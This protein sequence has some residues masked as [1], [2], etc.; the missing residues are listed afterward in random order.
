MQI[1]KLNDNREKKYWNFFCTMM[2]ALKLRSRE[3]L[4]Q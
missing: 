2:S 3:D 1:W 4:V